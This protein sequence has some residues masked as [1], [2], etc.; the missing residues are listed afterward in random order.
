MFE[1]TM[2]AVFFQ[3]EKEKTGPRKKGSKAGPLRRRT[4]QGQPQEVLRDLAEEV[5]S[6]KFKILSPVRLTN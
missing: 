5:N 4:K 1:V 2:F 3:T 6:R